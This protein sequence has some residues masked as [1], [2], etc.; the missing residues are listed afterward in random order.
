[1]VSIATGLSFGLAFCNH[2][3]LNPENVG[4]VTLKAAPDEVLHV[5]PEIFVSAKDLEAIALL[6]KNESTQGEHT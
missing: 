5:V 4:V 2:F 3:G 1:M 6:M